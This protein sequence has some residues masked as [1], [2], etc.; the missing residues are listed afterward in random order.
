MATAEEGNDPLE[1][2]EVP[3][4]YSAVPYPGD[5]VAIY[6]EEAEGDAWIASDTTVTFGGDTQ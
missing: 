2:G 1:D 5:R 4:W 3:E 6:D